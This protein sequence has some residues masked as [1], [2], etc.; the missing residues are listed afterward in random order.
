M[1]V[2]PLCLPPASC[3]F[4]AAK[5]GDLEAVQSFS[6]RVDDEPLV[7]KEIAADFLD[8][9]G[10]SIAAELQ[11]LAAEPISVGLH[12]E[13]SLERIAVVSC[14][15]DEQVAGFNVLF[16]FELGPF[17]MLQFSVV[18]GPRKHHKWRDKSVVQGL[19]CDTLA[20]QGL[21]SFDN[22]VLLQILSSLVWN[23]AATYHDQ[24]LF[25][26]QHKWR[27]KGC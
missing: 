18:N 14:L 19:L 27:D 23:L 10:D 15:I 22:L 8:S 25:K 7:G 16:P 4:G 5:A 13:P 6:D 20:E 17:F 2:S 3:E 12:E 9:V 11:E 1:E 24:V 21:C 26:I